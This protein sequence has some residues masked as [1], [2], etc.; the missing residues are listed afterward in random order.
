[1]EHQGEITEEVTWGPGRHRIIENVTITGQLTIDPFATVE[2]NPGKS[3]I[4]KD[5]GRLKAEG[6]LLLILWLIPIYEWTLKIFGLSIRVV[7]LDQLRVS[8]VSSTIVRVLPV[9]TIAFVPSPPKQEGDKEEPWGCI[10]AKSSRSS[11][12]NPAISLAGVWIENAG[13]TGQGNQASIIA[14]VEQTTNSLP[15]LKVNEVIINNSAGQGIYLREGRAGETGLAKF[16]EGSEELTIQNWGQAFRSEE[17]RYP[18]SLAAAAL[19]TLP[20]GNY[21]DKNP[22]SKLISKIY[23]SASPNITDDLEVIVENRGVPYYIDST[24]SVKAGMLAFKP[25]CEV[26]FPERKGL[27]IEESGKLKAE[28]TRFTS[29]I[30]QPSTLDERWSYILVQYPGEVFLTNVTLNNGGNGTD[31]ERASLAALEEDTILHLQNVTIENSAGCGVYLRNLASFTDESENLTIRNC[32][33]FPEENQLWQ[34]CP[35]FIDTS[36]TSMGTVPTGNYEGNALDKIYVSTSNE[37]TK[38]KTVTVNNRGVPYYVGPVSNF[39][40]AA[41]ATLQVNPGVEIQFDSDLIRHLSLKIESNDDGFGQLIIQGTPNDRVR[42]TSGASD[43]QKGDWGGVI[44]NDCFLTMGSKIE[45]ATIE[46]GGGNTGFHGYGCEG[47]DN[48]GL[49]VLISDQSLPEDDDDDILQVK[50][51]IFQ[52]SAMYGIDRG[53]EL[54]DDSDSKRFDFLNNGNNTFADCS[55]C[56]QTEPDYKDCQKCTKK[57]GDKQP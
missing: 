10:Q 45:Y 18:L 24:L 49:L 39:K 3:I 12:E 19:G 25:G 48:D 46:Y 17:Q 50:N 35:I 33:Q 31:Y 47:G 4:V 26:Q 5:K 55:G 6:F 40:V 56:Q 41:G 53:W 36:P 16:A 11:D 37:I 32:G 38:G 42:L 1:M 27:T 51:N 52:H 20:K 7:E 57:K 2:L 29:A 44:F 54:P 28:A 34:K 13:D 15:I 8:S 43:Q 23:V 9:Y 14:Q 21:Q 30:E 22:D